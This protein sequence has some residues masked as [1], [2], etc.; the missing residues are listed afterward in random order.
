MSKQETK[1]LIIKLGKQFLNNSNP[2]N[3]KIIKNEILGQVMSAGYDQKNM[4]TVK[5]GIEEWGDLNKYIIAVS[6]NKVD[7]KIKQFT[8]LCVA[9]LSTLI[10]LSELSD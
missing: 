6:A 4:S 2:D 3:L 8:N 1:N 9:G 10:N 7:E 5:I